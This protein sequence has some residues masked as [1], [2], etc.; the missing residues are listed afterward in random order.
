MHL[1]CIYLPEALALPQALTYLT[2]RVDI[3]FSKTFDILLFS[4]I[5]CNVCVMLS[6]IY[7]NAT[8][9]VNP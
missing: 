2:H 7:S 1:I 8:T 6:S 9:F 3:R 5:L 4:Y